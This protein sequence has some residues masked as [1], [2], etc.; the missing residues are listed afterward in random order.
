VKITPVLQGS[1]QGFAGTVEAYFDV[2]DRQAEDVSDLGVGETFEVLKDQGDSVFLRKTVD[3]AAYSRVHLLPDGDVIQGAGGG[4]GLPEHG[5]KFLVVC[6]FGDRI[7]PVGCTTEPV[8]NDVG[9]DAVDP[10]GNTGLTP[11]LLE[12]PADLDHGFLG[13]VLGVPLPGHP[14]EV[15]VKL[16]LELGVDPGKIKRSFRHQTPPRRYWKV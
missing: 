10:G 16:R 8:P 1:L 15:A 12:S 14:D 3:E 11:K 6:S 9:G 4:T 2:V 13:Q 7:G 5:R